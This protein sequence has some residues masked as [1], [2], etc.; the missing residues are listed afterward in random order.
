MK[1]PGV[2][3]SP[4]LN[5][6]L[7]APGPRVGLAPARSAEHGMAFT[8]FSLGML[9]GRATTGKCRSRRNGDR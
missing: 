8:I 9:G 4:D 3:S 6:L 1:H 7:H 2:R 5:V